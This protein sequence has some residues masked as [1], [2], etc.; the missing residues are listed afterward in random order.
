MIHVFKALTEEV[1][2]MQTQMGSFGREQ[3][4]LMEMPGTENAATP[5]KSALDTLFRRLD[6]AEKRIHE[7]EY[8]SMSTEI[9][10][11][12]TQRGRKIRWGREKAEQSIQEPQE[13]IKRLTHA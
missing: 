12:E 7:P 10:H 2:S 11:L 9:I 6:P 5:V 3:D 4:I 13:D 8:I 1:H